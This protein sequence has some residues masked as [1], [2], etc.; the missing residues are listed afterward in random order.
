MTEFVSTDGRGAAPASRK[1][2]LRIR[3][4]LHV[5]G[6]QAQRGVGRFSPRH[7]GPPAE[8]ALGRREQE[9]ALAIEWNRPDPGERL[10]VEIG[11]ARVQTEVAEPAL[12]VD[13]GER[14]HGDHDVRMIQRER[15]GERRDD[16]ERGRDGAQAEPADQSL[17][18]LRGVLLEAGRV[19]Q[20]AGGPSRAP[21]RPPG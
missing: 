7:R 15:R 2:A 9:V 3:A 19:G 10:V 14:Q 5:R 16:G 18:S 20:D 12:D 21:A 1:W 6:E 4:V 13:G 11:D 8:R 17:A